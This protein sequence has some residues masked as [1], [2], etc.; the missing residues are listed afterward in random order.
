MSVVWTRPVGPSVTEYIPRRLDAEL[1]AT[2]RDLLGQ[3]I[4]A[5]D[6]PMVSTDEYLTL[7]ARLDPQIRALGRDEQ[8]HIVMALA[9]VA[10]SSLT[11][12][13]IRV[14]GMGTE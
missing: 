10:L 12:R 4:Q 13:S 2:G 6:N 9:D 7:I 1:S 3:L 11:G 8:A 14:T 5:H